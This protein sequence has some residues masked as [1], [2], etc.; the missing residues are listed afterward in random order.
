MLLVQSVPPAPQTQIMQFLEIKSSF[1]TLLLGI[2]QH[3][4]TQLESLDVIVYTLKS[5]HISFLREESTVFQ[6]KLL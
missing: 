5:L 1:K 2:V 3:S 6:Y 4:R